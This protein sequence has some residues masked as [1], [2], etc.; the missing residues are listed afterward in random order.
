LARLNFYAGLL[1]PFDF[2]HLL[3]HAVVICREA[4]I[5]CIAP[6]S[7]YLMQ[8]MAMEA[9]QLIQADQRRR[10]ISK[11]LQMKACL[12]SRHALRPKRLLAASTRTLL[13]QVSRCKQ[14]LTSNL[15]YCVCLC[16]LAPFSDGGCNQSCLSCIALHPTE[17]RLKVSLQFTDVVNIF[18]SLWESTR[19]TQVKKA[20]NKAVTSSESQISMCNYV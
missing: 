10:T 16:K 15:K 18:T 7:I 1:F 14:G 20:A 13:Q 8:K 2:V 12:P 19:Q 3:L 9:K 5:I 17:D 11:D 4:K 6:T